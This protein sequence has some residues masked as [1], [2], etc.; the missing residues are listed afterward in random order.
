MGGEKF[1]STHPEGYLFGEN[2][3]LNF[4]GSRP[5]A[6]G[7]LTLQLNFK[8]CFDCNLQMK[9]NACHLTAFTA[10]AD[11]CHLYAG[12]AVRLFLVMSS[13]TTL[14]ISLCLFC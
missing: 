7:F 2:T 1:D 3:D 10:F 5:V 8:D 11:F 4:L 6:V 13:D 14:L 9:N 12:K